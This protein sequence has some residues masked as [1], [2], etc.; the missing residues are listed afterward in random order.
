MEIKRKSAKSV[1]W[2]IAKPDQ[3]IALVSNIEKNPFFN[4]TENPL[5]ALKPVDH[6]CYDICG[7][8]IRVESSYVNDRKVGVID[9][10]KSELQQ[11]RDLNRFKVNLVENQ[12]K[13]KKSFLI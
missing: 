4:L 7:A 13:I 6:C 10:M 12:S 11:I 1:R 8:I 5:G 9:L 2:W 3:S